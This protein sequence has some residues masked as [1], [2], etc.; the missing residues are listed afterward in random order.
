MYYSVCY[1]HFLEI[2]QDGNNVL[3]HAFHNTCR[4]TRSGRV[5]V[6]AKASLRISGNGLRRHSLYFSEQK[7]PQ[8]DLTH[9]P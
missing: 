2:S 4:V 1:W 7:K 5:C 8:Q 6:C 9:Y 3:A